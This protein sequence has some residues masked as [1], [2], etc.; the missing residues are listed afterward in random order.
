MHT[1]CP[2]LMSHSSKRAK[3]WPVNKFLVRSMLLGH[4]G[5]DILTSSTKCR[6]ELDLNRPLRAEI[7]FRKDMAIG[8]EF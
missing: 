3:T 6:I 4:G 2:M 7:D 8:R 5:S 1:D